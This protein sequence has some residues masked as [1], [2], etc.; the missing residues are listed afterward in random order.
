MPPRRTA[1]G[2]TLDGELANGLDAV[3]ALRLEPRP[4]EPGFFVFG[5][6]YIVSEM[7]S[8]GLPPGIVIDER[9][10]HL[11]ARI[12]ECL[13]HPLAESFRENLQRLSGFAQGGR[14]VRIGLDFAPLSFGFAV[15]RADGSA[16]IYGGLIFHAN[17]DRG[18]DGGA[19]TYSVCLEPTS[20]WALHT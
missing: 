18:G 17:H 11:V 13:E 15:I 4:I 6:V 20:G 14:K 3:E 5:E 12:R 16:W 8:L 7:S 2:E 10:E 9:N 19:P 1:I